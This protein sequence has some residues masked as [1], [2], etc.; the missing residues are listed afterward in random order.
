MFS[1]VSTGEWY[2]TYTNGHLCKW[3]DESLWRCFN[4]RKRQGLN[5]SFNSLPSIPLLAINFFVDTYN[6]FFILDSLHIEFSF[7]LC[8]VLAAISTSCS[9][10]SEASSCCIHGE[11]NMRL[12]SPLSQSP[13]SHLR[14][15]FK[16]CRIQFGSLRC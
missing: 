13:L 8:L 11:K 6:H 14:L 7:S 10:C 3:C 12:G 5:T 2:S 4:K 9:H 16:V 15:S 1:W